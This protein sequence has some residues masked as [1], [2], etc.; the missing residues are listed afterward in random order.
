MMS[1]RLDP[2]ERARRAAVYRAIGDEFADAQVRGMEAS[3]AEL[4]GWHIE[5]EK[6]RARWRQF[7]GGWD[8]MIAPIT[9]GPAFPHLELGETP[10]LESARRTLEINGRTQPY[11]MQLFFPSISTLAG[12]PATA[13]PA[14]FS[15]DGLPV[16]LQAIGPY[17]EDRTP[18]CFAGLLARELDGIRTPPRFA[19]C[20][21]SARQ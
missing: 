4:F 18:L 13:F 19:D 12:L 10:M 15:R 17:L 11:Q 7:F 2:E 20:A 5:R 21:E 16:A 1:A 3:A 6:I 8:V 14:G 9:L